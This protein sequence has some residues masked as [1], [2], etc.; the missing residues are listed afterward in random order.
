MTLSDYP[1]FRKDFTQL[2]RHL[3][4]ALAVQ[5]LLMAAVPAVTRMVPNL[6]GLRLALALPLNQWFP[7]I[8]IVVCAVVALVAAA[9]W[10]AEERGDG[11]H[12]FLRR[13]AA[14]RA[15]V[16]GEKA[17]AGL[18]VIV[19]ILLCQWL[20]YAFAR[21]CGVEIWDPEEG[22]G[23]YLLGITLTSYLVGLPLSC[24]LSQSI[25]VVALGLGIEIT[26]I[27]F[28]TLWRLPRAPGAGTALL[29]M[30]TLAIPIAA[31]FSL[32]RPRAGRWIARRRPSRSGALALIFKQVHENALIYIIASLLAGV[33]IAFAVWEPSLPMRVALIV[34][35]TLH[36]VV[37]GI[38]TYGQSEKEGVR[39]VLYHHPIPRSTI[40]WAKFL[41]GFLAAILLACILAVMIPKP[42]EPFFAHAGTNV[43]PFRA[44]VV[45]VSLLPYCYG[46]LVTHA[47]VRPLYA[48][49]ATLPAVVVSLVPIAYIVAMRLMHL[50]FITLAPMTRQDA[51]PSSLLTSAF[52]WPVFLIVAGLSLAGWRAATDRTLLTAT[53]VFRQ[54]YVVR[55]LLFVL[56]MAVIVATTGWRDLFFLLTNIDLRA[57]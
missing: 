37:L 2:G 16:W 4:G 36:S 54:V 17:A 22:I 29:V 53:S 14:S 7:K 39:C 32:G 43:W 47:F 50:L 5:G 3:V 20:W 51:A 34:A 52:S 31:G 56:S 24:L 12:W 41:P 45:L 46:V 1:V 42:G 27:W 28:Y 33:G 57:G 35:V 18:I 44:L 9:Y 13:L 48:V 11:N 38:S 15:R 40:Y 19:G 8:Q 55:L 25:G 10:S 26:G 49:M 23:L 21:M 30:L 6:P